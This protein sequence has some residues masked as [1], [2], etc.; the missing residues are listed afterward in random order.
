MGNKHNAYSFP[1]S[2]VIGSEK[3]AELRKKAE[4][5]MQPE[6]KLALFK[7]L[8]ADGRKP[9]NER[10]WKR[11]IGSLPAMWLRD[12]LNLPAPKQGEKLKDK[13]KSKGKDQC[14]ALIWKAVDEVLSNTRCALENG[15]RLSIVDEM[16]C[17]TIDHIAFWAGLIGQEKAPEVEAQS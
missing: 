12:A 9:F 11:R 7:E 6:H 4:D 14:Q 8:V 5:A 13:R 17:Q 1:I 15:S 10:K 2:S 3:L 16:F